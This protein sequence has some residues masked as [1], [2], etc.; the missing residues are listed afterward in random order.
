MAIVLKI[1][2]LRYCKEITSETH[3]QS[4]LT[5]I[6]RYIY[7]NLYL[8][9]AYTIWFITSGKTIMFTMSIVAGTVL[10]AEEPVKYIL[11]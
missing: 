9:N 4:K 7:F 1:I 10:R 6:N 2:P 8:L 3:F 11:Y 5:F